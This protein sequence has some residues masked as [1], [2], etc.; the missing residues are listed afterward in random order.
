M[1]KLMG[2]KV[3]QPASEIIR[4]PAP[5]LPPGYAELLENVEKL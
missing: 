1:A 4:G 5:F 3:L 2:K